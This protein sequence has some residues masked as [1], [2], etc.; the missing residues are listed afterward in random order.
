MKLSKNNLNVRFISLLLTLVMFFQGIQAAFADSDNDIVGAVYVGTNDPVANGVLMFHRLRDGTLTLVPGSPFLTRG[1]GTGTGVELP[2][3]P[4]GSQGSLIVDKKNKFLYIVNA[5]SNEVSVFK[6]HPDRLTLVDTVSSEGVFPNSLTVHKN[7]LYVLNSAYNFSFTGFKVAKDGHLKLLQGPCY[8]L[9]P[10]NQAP[11]IGSGQPLVSIVP[12]QISFTPN[13]KQLIIS[14]KEGITS[15]VTLLPLAGPG[16]IDVYRLHKC[17]TVVDCEHPTSNINTRVP[18]GQFPFGFT[19]SE[20]GDLIMTEAAGVPPTPPS[21]ASALST[22]KIKGNGKLKV[23]SADVPNEQ[24]ATCW[25]ARFGKFVYA[26]NNLSNSIS[27]YI[28]SKD[29]ALTLINEQIVVLGTVDAPAFPI[30]LAISSHGPFLYQL[31]E[32]VEAVIYVYKINKENGD[33]TFI[34]K[35]SVG[36]SFAGQVGLAIADFNCR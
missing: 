27:L 36:A 33:L 23:I 26:A 29:G 31:S 11:I 2:V 10:L 28:V 21:K 15:P 30:D 9:P 14:R 3:D 17:G 24:F 19:F 18:F 35:V 6:I 4:L 25:A 32:G 8:L 5:G 7:V 34:Q 13:G 16:R 20:Q 1:K 12:G 22:Y